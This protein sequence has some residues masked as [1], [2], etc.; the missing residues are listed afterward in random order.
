V[1]P[2][3]RAPYRVG[4]SWMLGTFAAYLLFGDTSGLDDMFVLIAFV[5]IATGTWALGYRH[6]VRTF[7]MDSLRSRY[8]ERATNW[9]RQ[10][11]AAQRWVRWS[12]LYFIVYSWQMLLLYGATPS[13]FW[14]VVSDPGKCQGTVGTARWRT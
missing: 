11:E 12:G 10:T 1:S 4:V 13:T 6:G 9:P 8:G 3:A 14:Q 7:P 5:L 2:T